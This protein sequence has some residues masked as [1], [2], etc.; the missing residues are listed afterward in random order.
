MRR[1]ENKVIWRMDQKIVA[2]IALSS[3]L[4]ISQYTNSLWI[5]ARTDLKVSK[6]TSS[7]LTI[8]W[9]P[10]N[11]SVVGY[12]VRYR[13]NDISPI[14]PVNS[15]CTPASNGTAVQQFCMKHSMN[16]SSIFVCNDKTTVRL[17]NLTLYTFYWIEVTAFTYKSFAN[18]SSRIIN[19]TDEGIPSSPP[20]N[21]TAYVH[22]S[23]TICVAWLPVPRENRNGR[24]IKYH[25]DMNNG[26]S[27]TPYKYV[28]VSEG[29]EDIAQ[30]VTVY[31]LR[32][33]TSYTVKVSAKTSKGFSR[34]SNDIKVTTAEDA[35]DKAPTNLTVIK[36]TADSIQ[37][38]W[39]P[40]PRESLNGKLCGYKI[41]W[42]EEKAEHYTYQELRIKG[43][44]AGRKKR[45][46]DYLDHPPT[47]FTLRNLTVYTNYSVEIAAHTGAEEGLGPYSQAYFMSGEGVP[48]YP[49]RN[50]T[51]Y[52]TS[53]HE[54][55][56]EWIPPVQEKIHG[57]LAG[58]DVTFMPSHN[59]SSIHHMMIF[60]SKRE[61]YL[62]SLT[63]FTFYNIT[64]AAFTKVG[65]G[66]ASD[67]IQTRTDESTPEVPPENFTAE[68]RSFDSINVSWKPVPIKL[69]RG[70]IIGYKLEVNSSNTVFHR[71]PWNVTSTVI[72]NLQMFI[73]YKLHVR[74]FTRKGD[75]PWSHVI[76]LRTKNRAPSVIPTN[77]TATPIGTTSV[78]LTWAIRGLER[79]FILQS[80]VV[81]YRALKNGTWGDAVKKH[82][83]TN[84]TSEIFQGQ[85]VFSKE[86]EII[87]G[88]DVFT[89]YEIQM[90]AYAANL[91]GNF[92]RPIN[93]TTKE[94]VPS[95][96]VNV[97]T[98][99]W[100]LS[101]V[102]VDWDEVPLDDRNGNITG[103]IV[104][105]R[106]GSCLI[107]N[108]TVD[109]ENNRTAVLDDLEMFVTYNIR[110]R[111][112][113]KAGPGR[114]SSPVN[115]TTNQT[116]PDVN[117]TFLY[118]NATSNSSIDVS[119][120]IQHINK[121]LN[122]PT[123]YRLSYCPKKY[124]EKYSA[125]DPVNLN[126]L[127]EYSLGNLTTYVEYKIRVMAMDITAKDGTK[128]LI[129]SGNF[130]KPIYGRTLEGVPGAA[131]SNVSATPE[132]TTSILVRWGKLP[133]DKVNANI[134][135]YTIKLYNGSTLE[136]L[137][138]NHVSSHEFS[139]LI[140][141]LEVYSNY[142]VQ[143]QA[144]AKTGS[145][146]FSEFV[147][148]TTHQPAPTV[149]PQN[150]KAVATGTTTILVT[151][152]RLERKS[153]VG[154]QLQGYHIK[155]TNSVL[156]E[157]ERTQNV[158]DV[159]NFTLTNLKIFAEYKIQV[160]ARSTQPGNFSSPKTVRTHEGVPS[161]P[162]GIA[163][164]EV[165][166]SISVR[167]H[168]SPIP[169]EFHN[170]IIRGY[171]ISYERLVNGTY[172]EKTTVPPART[173]MLLNL[174]K[175]T[176]YHGKILAY[177]NAGDG[178]E[179]N[180]TF[181]TADDI[182]SQPPVELKPVN[183]ISPTKLNVTWK[184]VPEQFRHGSLTKYIVTYQRV[185]VGD[186]KTEE[187]EVNYTE[188]YA[189]QTHVSLT[190]LEPYVEYKVSVAAATS[191][192][193]GP[194]AF[195]IGET[196]HCE[197]TLTT[198]WRRYEPYA[199]VSDDGQP[200]EIIPWVLKEM[201][202]ECCGSCSEFQTTVVNFKRDGS[203][204][205]SAK[206]SSHFLLKSLD[207]SS[208]FTFPIY[209]SSLQDSYRG[210]FGYVPVIESSGVAFIV[211]PEVST[212]Q[213]TMFNS[214]IRCL[215][216]LLLPMVT[217]Y[218][219]GVIIWILERTGNAKDFHPSF[220]RGTW[221]GIW[222][223]FVSMTTLGYG[224][225]APLSYKGRLFAVIWI[226]FGLVVIAVT[227]AMLTT[228]LTTV[229]LKSATK[230][231]GS[232]IAAEQNSPEYHLG[233]RRNAKYE[234]GKEYHSLEEVTKALL[235]REVQGILVDAYSAGLRNDLFSKFEVS[236]IVDYKTAYGI[237]LS[238]R[239]TPLRKCFHRYLQSH[240]AELFK[241]IKSKVR[242]IQTSNSTDKEEV[243]SGGLF[244][245][246][247]EEFRK[248]L[249]YASISLG[250]ALFFSLMY[251][252][253]RRIRSREK[254][255]QKVNFKEI[256]QKEMNML[257][258]EF[259]QRMRKIKEALG[260]K[261]RRQII[262][263]WKLRRKTSFEARWLRISQVTPIHS[264]EVTVTELT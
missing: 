49:P 180:L 223:S 189:N 174:D 139:F 90:A 19:H 235:K 38:S 207:T 241:M 224:D 18:K 84:E 98:R 182:P 150:V 138:S 81:S 151:W 87:E 108:R 64:V 152:N 24:I 200:G 117:L 173:L 91:T 158:D 237:V 193:K 39:Q 230:I 194:F 124:C 102:R 89:K 115:A 248:A 116:I 222:W 214:I 120:K 170:G 257:V 159:D 123:R 198:S 255:H 243:V 157:H 225:R 97:R 165:L 251:E 172:Q 126:T 83:P 218:A 69:Q 229:T 21:V 56:V 113:T 144:V 20:V 190:N 73:E 153:I 8:D 46:V 179:A 254:V 263:F 160:A 118:A 184:P 186:V 215:P 28:Y 111:A 220:I 262:R 44:S 36:V 258:E 15:R 238:P 11:A 130:S 1:P 66:N 183:R 259:F 162:P 228:A 112:K 70:I 32:K 104:E 141:G 252:V 166:D 133:W 203:N 245:S 244:D 247:S 239:S 106:N 2:L 3:I 77:V 103:Y 43:P 55:R 148:I 35:P 27:H 177:T 156:G 231:Y 205:E 125:D 41:R 99:S 164:P 250:V 211:Y 78:H 240:R 92:S 23:T 168:W 121:R 74:A 26:G 210:G 95:P 65:I 67:M 135:Q 71:F 58:F 145:G 188:V 40:V 60:G 209:G 13:R 51:A 181:K 5:P 132:S 25:L 105:L 221:D 216:V 195:V 85:Q 31:G 232:K 201:V 253:I 171:R 236:E 22:N 59:E 52:N 94:G 212:Q 176:K 185:K 14:V 136:H 7:S 80:F 76:P 137:R 68:S 17:K 34:A 47:N 161:K 33:Y 169:N 142:S 149:V 93:V 30:N 107:E 57:E 146:P 72:G 29:E 48:T 249:R 62:S 16:Y 114:P 163:Q 122:E 54:I 88:L 12:R 4:A 219:A 128:V 264:K 61:V 206:N 96:P 246:S 204:E 175:A 140:N 37:I 191:K 197:S 10:V 127:F 256:L 226:Y 79:G 109:G 119:W 154:F 82:V 147:N 196:C 192:G 208:D 42:K 86:Y 178:K 227:M 217:A 143:V 167:L 75:G 63:V 129:P 187:E 110:V 199:N 53:A 155:Y 213:N 131:P 101:S 242:P 261:H 6:R 45:A 202:D 50:V 9:C 233:T 234:P 134:T 100:S 260:E